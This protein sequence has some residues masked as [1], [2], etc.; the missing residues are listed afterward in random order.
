MRKAGLR[1]GEDAS[2][3]EA[4]VNIWYL[5]AKEGWYE[6]IVFCPCAGLRCIDFSIL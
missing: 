6:I 5:L 3:V 1:T 2:E 4:K